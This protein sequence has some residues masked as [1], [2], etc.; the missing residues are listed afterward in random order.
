MFDRIGIVR[1]LV[2]AVVFELVAVPLSLFVFHSYPMPLL[3]QIVV[4]S[5]ASAIGRLVEVDLRQQ[6]ERKDKKEAKDNEATCVMT[7]SFKMSLCLEELF[8]SVRSVGG[9]T[10]SEGKKAGLGRY[11]RGINERMTIKIQRYKLGYVLEVEFPLDGPVKPSC[12]EETFIEIQ[13]D[14]LPRMQVQHV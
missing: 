9:Y 12:R 10:W 4:L 1:A 2:V 8:E 6:K 14:L 7:A 3:I 11:I 5:C 13:R